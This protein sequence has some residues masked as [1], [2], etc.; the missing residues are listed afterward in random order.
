VGAAMM[1]SIPWEKI[2]LIHPVA[3]L[4]VAVIF[5]A[6]IDLFYKSLAHA[7]KVSAE[8]RAIA[9]CLAENRTDK[10]LRK[11]LDELAQVT[12]VLE[13]VRADG[14]RK[15]QE[16]IE[17][18][19]ELVYQKREK[20]RAIRSASEIAQVVKEQKVARQMMCS[21]CDGNVLRKIDNQ[22]IGSEIHEVEGELDGE[23]V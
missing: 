9:A 12:H 4:S 2:I 19:S 5:I 21:A 7:I 6:A 8:V 23:A 17:L 13:G 14:E 3:W 1:N 16:I 11:A 20:V 22:T 18:G 15:G 10:N